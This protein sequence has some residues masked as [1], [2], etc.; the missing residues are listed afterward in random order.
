MMWCTCTGFTFKTGGG[1][2]DAAHPQHGQHRREIRLG[3][4]TPPLIHSSNTL[5]Q[6][7]SITMIAMLRPRSYLLVI[8]LARVVLV[9]CNRSSTALGRHAN[10]VSSSVIATANRIPKQKGYEIRGLSAQVAVY[11]HS[12]YTQAII[13]CSRSSLPRSERGHILP[14]SIYIIFL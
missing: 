5:F 2:G 13:L 8:S 10:A 9:D 1:G 11:Y 6:F 7:Y 4:L 3:R 12:I 14:L